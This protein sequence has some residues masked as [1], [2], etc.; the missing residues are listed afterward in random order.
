MKKSSSP[1]KAKLEFV[2]SPQ[3]EGKAVEETL[4]VLPK[5]YPYSFVFVADEQTLDTAGFPFICIDL[6][7]ER[8]AKF[9]VDASHIASVAN[10]LSLANMDFTEFVEA[11]KKHGV[12]RGF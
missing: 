8:R 3:F 5:N 9:R 7:D 6:L 11:S 1:F 4:A 12:F 10:N 2:A